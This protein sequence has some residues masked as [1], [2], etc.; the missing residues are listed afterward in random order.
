MKETDEKGTWDVETS[1]S[2]VKIRVL[3]QPAHGSTGNTPKEDA[4]AENVRQIIAE[5]KKQGLI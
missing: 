3:T 4:F 1:G 5:A 2:G